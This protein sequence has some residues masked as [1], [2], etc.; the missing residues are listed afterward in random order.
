MAENYFHV[1]LFK[2]DIKKAQSD[3]DQF[4]AERGFK[5]IDEHSGN[6]AAEI[7]F[8]IRKNERIFI[9][10]PRSNDW[11]SLYG[12]IREDELMQCAEYLSLKNHSKALWLMVY[13]G[14]VFLYNIFK[15]GEMIA[16]YNSSPN[17]FE[18]RITNREIIKSKEDSALL[19]REFP[20]LKKHQK[21]LK[22]MLTEAW[23]ISEKDFER[24]SKYL[25]PVILMNDFGALIGIKKNRLN[26]NYT[27]LLSDTDLLK[28]FPDCA[29]WRIIRYR[30]SSLSWFWL[31]LVL[32]IFS[33]KLY[34]L[35]ASY[36]WKNSRSRQLFAF[37]LFVATSCKKFYFVLS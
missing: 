9:I 7:N 14:D 2:T 29:K 5:K 33:G 35:I 13:E 15:N 8:K 23:V 17:Y 30:R 6:Q 4:M 22:Q 28:S 1:H 20:Q 27:M 10:A 37:D 36:F 3:L 11:I 34:Q 32:F 31:L 18:D 19:A 12:S 24:D 25:D 26:L 16:E 21:K